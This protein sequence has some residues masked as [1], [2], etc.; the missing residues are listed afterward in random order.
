MS[1][2]RSNQAKEQRGI[3]VRIQEKIAKF[4]F[5]LNLNLKVQFKSPLSSIFFF[6]IR[7]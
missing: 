6:K 4:H 2:L 3:R 5:F 1:I 7:A